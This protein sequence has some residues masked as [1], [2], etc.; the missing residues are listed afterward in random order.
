[1]TNTGLLQFGDLSENNSIII[2]N[3]NFI[4][5]AHK[6]NFILLSLHKY[7]S[8]LERYSMQK[9]NYALFV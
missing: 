2:L 8:I 1:M 7:Q 5:M 9:L 6:A 3:I 4:H